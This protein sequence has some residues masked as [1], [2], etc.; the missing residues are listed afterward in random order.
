MEEVLGNFPVYIN[1]VQLKGTPSDLLRGRDRELRF[2]PIIKSLGVAK[3]PET[4][5]IVMKFK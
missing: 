3:E 2:A 1:T 5:I 4:A